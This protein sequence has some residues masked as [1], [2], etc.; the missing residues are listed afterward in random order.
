MRR[1]AGQ[2]ETK[3]SKGKDLSDVTLLMFT[4]KG[5]RI[6]KPSLS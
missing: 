1:R 3:A 5:K 4:L 6:L 2:R